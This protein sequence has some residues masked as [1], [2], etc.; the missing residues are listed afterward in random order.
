[1]SAIRVLND[2]ECIPDLAQAL[3]VRAQAALA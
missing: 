2:R 1:M 3:P